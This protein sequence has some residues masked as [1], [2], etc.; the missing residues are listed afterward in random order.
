LK[1]RKKIQERR[2][3]E[4]QR[5]NGI[6]IYRPLHYKWADYGGLDMLNVKTVLIATSTVCRWELVRS[7]A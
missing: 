5:I 1:E 6:G 7:D 4:D 2:K 3:I